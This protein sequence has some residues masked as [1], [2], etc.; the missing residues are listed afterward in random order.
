M[1]FIWSKCPEDDLEMEQTFLEFREITRKSKI[2][3]VTLPGSSQIQP[4]K[5]N[6][7]DVGGSKI[8]YTMDIDDTLALLIGNTDVENPCSYWE[9]MVDGEVTVSNKLQEAGLLTPNNRKTTIY[10]DENQTKSL[11]GYFSDKF[12]HLATQNRFV[13]DT[14][15]HQTTP[16]KGNLFSSEEEMM[17]NIDTW[18][19]L[20]ESFAEDIDRLY[21][22]SMPNAGDCINYIIIKDNSGYSLRYFGF[23]FASKTGSC[24]KCTP[25][26][27]D[28]SSARYQSFKYD[29]L[30]QA[31]EYC[32][33]QEYEGW[34]K[35]KFI[36][37]GDQISIIVD[38]IYPKPSNY[39]EARGCILC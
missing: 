5:I 23:D 25:E 10:L 12:S 7:I 34:G 6:R 4:T 36:S 31:I 15:N 32:I 21:Q 35:P 33:F 27:I 22:L 8:A 28:P 18:K 37:N 24:L 9:N 2:I 14:K 13:L 39:I 11:P 38:Q 30:R 29:H 3:Y 17:S 16:W 19:H 1:Y 20:L 26:D